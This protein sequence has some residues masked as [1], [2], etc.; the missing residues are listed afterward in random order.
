MKRRKFV[1]ASALGVV[2]LGNPSGAQPAPTGE[3]QVL[4]LRKYTFASPEKL[5]AFEHFA[6]SALI[7]ALNRAGVKPVGLFKVMKS[8]NPEAAFPGDMSLELFA[9]LPHSSLASAATL[10]SR[11]ATDA[12]HTAAATALGE[13]A[14]DPAFTRYESSLF[15][16]FD[17]C[18]RVETPAKGSARVMQLRIYE[19]ANAERGR[20]KVHMFNEGGEIR[21]FR[22]TGLNPV[23]FGHAFAG[24]KLPNLTYMLGFDNDAAMKAAWAKFTTHPDWI[25]LRADPLYRDTV[26]AITNLVLRPIDGSQI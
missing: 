23:F 7:P 9:L 19:A 26:S 15:L 18:P 20:M 5:H 10:D 24:V 2:A 12:A 17:H 25:K 14:R 13:T 1:A 16:G 22:E 4:E 8:D 11:I 21:I 6:G 3:R